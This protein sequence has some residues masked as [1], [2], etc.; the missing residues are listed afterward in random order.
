MINSNILKYFILA[1]L[2]FFALFLMIE[3]ALLPVALLIISIFLILIVKY[4]KY[5]ILLLFLVKPVLDATYFYKI[6][7]LGLNFLQIT[8]VM[9]PIF[10]IL[11]LASLKTDL[12]KYHL[13]RII[14][15][16]FLTSV[17]SFVIYLLNYFY[18]SPSQLISLF[19]S[20]LVILFQFSNG[21][22]AYFLL[23]RL[24]HKE[25]EKKLFFKM[26]IFASLFPLITAYLQVGGFFEGRTIRTTGELIRLTGLYHDSS[27]LRFYSFQSIVIILIYLQ[28]YGLKTKIVY[29][30]MLFGLIPLFIIIIYLGYSKAAIAILLAWS[31]IYI[32]VSRNYF[33]GG[34]LLGLFISSYF[35]VTKISAEVDKL[36]YKEIMFY[37]GTLSED[38]EYTMLGGRFVR[39]EAIIDRF[40]HKSDLIEQ[41]FGYYFTIGIRSHN[42][43]LRIIISYGYIGFLLYSIF[44]FRIAFKVIISYKKHKDGLAFGAI[45]LLVSFLIDS[46]GLTPS[47]YTGYSWIVFGVISLS[48]NRDII[49]EKKE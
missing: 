18:Y 6:P 4:P 38:L 29:R 46:I 45:L 23:P 21:L 11:I 30:L 8:G 15:L 14:I 42:D 25:N 36:F 43:F 2:T 12:S 47:I 28:Q 19:I 26:M 24:F 35:F 33:L 9:F 22:C 16:L 41:L 17:I 40:F 1:A 44:I 7:V 27:N 31:C 5:G 32:F 20:S 37:E 49:P 34:L 10:T 13:S 39:W 48:I 3:S